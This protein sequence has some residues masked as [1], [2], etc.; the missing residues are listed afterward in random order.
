ML[1]YNWKVPLQ[2]QSSQVPVYFDS[3]CAKVKDIFYTQVE[4]IFIFSTQAEDIFH[5]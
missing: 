2:L 4:G 3:L 5:T 1:A